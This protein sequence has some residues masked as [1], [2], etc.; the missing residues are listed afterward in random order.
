[1]QRT[2]V[3]VTLDC[4][5]ESMRVVSWGLLA[6]ACWFVVGVVGLAVPVVAGRRGRCGV[7]LSGGSEAGMSAGNASQS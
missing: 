6:V 7:L 1:M 4:L 5:M 2:R 3:F